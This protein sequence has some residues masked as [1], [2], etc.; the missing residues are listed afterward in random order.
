MTF[1]NTVQASPQLMIQY[2]ED[3]ISQEMMV[4]NVMRMLQRAAFFEVQNQLPDMHRDSLKRSLSVLQAKGKI[5]KDT[6]KKRMV[7]N[8]DTKKKCHQY[9]T[10]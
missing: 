8:P 7:V 9:F 4:M 2:T 3:S 10:L 6:N 5:V 1:F